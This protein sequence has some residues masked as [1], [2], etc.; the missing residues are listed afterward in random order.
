M[1]RFLEMQTFAAVVDAGSFVKAAETL[2]LSKAAMSRYV[3]DLETRLGVRL[4][5]RTTRRL[6]LTGE[7]EVFYARSKELL[8]GVDEAEAEITSRTGAASGLL[9]VNAPVTFGILHLAPLWG[10]FR[11]QYPQVALDVTLA[12]RVVDLVEEGYDV[13]IRIATLPNSTLIS[14][15]LTTTRMVLCASPQYLK[16]HGEPLHP[17]ELAAHAVISYSYWST[18]DEWHFEGPQGPVTVKTNPC[19]HTNSGD[20]CRAAALAHQ[21][22]ILQ[23]T[24]LVGDDLAAGTLVELMPQYRSLEMGIYAVYPTRKHV[25]PKVRALIDFLAG[26]FAKKPPFGA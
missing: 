12:D 3:G 11:S 7:G 21:G 15:R 19:I 23:P 13:A 17:A 22:I 10:V 5:H 26:H 1:D 14:K 9:R 18:K 25:A 2:G 8:A 20:T 4:L 16:T 24:F 6:S